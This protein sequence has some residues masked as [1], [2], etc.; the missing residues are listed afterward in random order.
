[1]PGKTLISSKLLINPA[2][3]DRDRSLLQHDTPTLWTLTALEHVSQQQK[4]TNPED[5]ERSGLNLK[6]KAPE[7]EEGLP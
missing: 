7:E 5:I 1:M 4:T 3:P 2:L 6:D